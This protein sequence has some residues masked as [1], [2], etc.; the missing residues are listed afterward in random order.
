MGRL[1]ANFARL[2]NPMQDCHL[3]KEPALRP[4]LPAGHCHPERKRRI[5]VKVDSVSV[6]AKYQSAGRL[7]FGN[8]FSIAHHSDLWPRTPFAAAQR[9][10]QGETRGTSRDLLFFHNIHF[11]FCLFS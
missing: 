5:S 4:Y 6:A 3:R 10:P 7:L 8:Q 9:S 1:R 2:G 11:P